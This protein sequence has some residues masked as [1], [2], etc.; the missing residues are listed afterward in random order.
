ML[1]SVGGEGT[2]WAHSPMALAGCHSQPKAALLGGESP[3][4]QDDNVFTGF[5]KYTVSHAHLASLK[6]N[7]CSYRGLRGRAP[8]DLH[9]ASFP[10]LVFSAEVDKSPVVWFI[11]LSNQ[12][13]VCCCRLL[14]FF[15][16]TIQA[17]QPF[18]ELPGAESEGCTH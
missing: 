18:Q 16:F 6:P 17:A 7:A 2:L 4:T 3:G 9:R 5:V 13:N 1:G 12:P 11:H 8:Q 10:M 14:L 15:F